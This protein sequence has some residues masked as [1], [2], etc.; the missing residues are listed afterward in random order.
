MHVGTHSSMKSAN[1][2]S[3]L[4][5]ALFEFDLTKLQA[6][7]ISLQFIDLEPSRSLWLELAISPHKL[8]EAND[9]ELEHLDFE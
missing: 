6:D 3:E 1:S 4:C 2:D 9:A 7:P 5:A 8:L